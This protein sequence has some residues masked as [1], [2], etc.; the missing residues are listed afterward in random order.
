MV[1]NNGRPLTLRHHMKL[2]TALTLPIHIL[3]RR[4]LLHGL[5][6]PRPYFSTALILSLTAASNS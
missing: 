6:N 2:F 1:P 5:V 3:N 4:S